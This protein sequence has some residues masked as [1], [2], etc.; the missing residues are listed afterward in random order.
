MTLS[1][2]DSVN[3]EPTRVSPLT[4]IGKWPFAGD[5]SW[6]GLIRKF[7]DLTCEWDLQAIEYKP[8][9]RFAVAE[10]LD[11]A[12]DYQLGK[13]LVQIMDDRNQGAFLLEACDEVRAEY[14][15]HRDPASL[16]R[17]TLYG[18]FAHDWSAKL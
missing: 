6:K 4:H 14:E 3:S 15:R 18:N 13:L 9:L 10:A 17:Q 16:L 8:F 2:K 5:Y 7:N 12:S 11:K 1:I